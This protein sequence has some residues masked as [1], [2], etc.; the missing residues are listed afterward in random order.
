MNTKVHFFKNGSITMK[1]ML[2][3]I[4]YYCLPILLFSQGI[5][6]TKGELI[7]DDVYW[8]HIQALCKY[9]DGSIGI[10]KK[11]FKKKGSDNP[12]Y[13]IEKYDS[14]YKRISSNLIKTPDLEG[15]KSNLFS[16]H[17]VGDHFYIYWYSKVEKTKTASIYF[18][19][20][21]DDGTATEIKKV[22]EMKDEK[23]LSKRWG[24]YPSPNNGT[25]II[26]KIIKNEKNS[27]TNFIFESFDSE[28]NLKWKQEY[29]PFKDKETSIIGD[30]TIG[31]DGYMAMVVNDWS[32]KSTFE[33]GID[34]QLWICTE[35]G[36]SKTYPL[37][38]PKGYAIKS[39]LISFTESSIN[40]L[41]TYADIN[42]KKKL[43]NPAD[44]GAVGTFA[45]SIDKNDYKIVHQAFTPF[46]KE[47]FDY[48]L[49]KEKDREDGLIGLYITDLVAHEPSKSYLVLDKINSNE[50]V[51]GNKYHNSI[52][53]DGGIVVTYQNGQPQKHLILPKGMHSDDEYAGLGLLVQKTGEDIHFL[54]NDAPKNRNLN[55]KSDL[56]DIGESPMSTTNS[57][58]KK[59]AD[60]MCI[61]LSADGNPKKK[62]LLGYKE[63]DVFLNHLISFPLDNDSFIFITGMDGK[64]QLNKLT[65]SK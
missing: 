48:Y 39:T 37:N 22:T 16:L 27:V 14:N 51:S 52:F 36:I 40:L 62:F 35:K 20:L 9:N 31:K 60:V 47:V 53:S 54:Y 43:L 29:S 13:Y 41:G 19:V 7:S 56:E 21:A 64:Y 44:F 12:D 3:L 65:Y 2:V 5:T 30:L 6:L 32:K 34:Q 4:T 28:L 50:Y 23:D 61:T 55:L 57:L 1:K 26:K 18:S 45:I 49:V 8:A 46:P 25:W 58:V 15:G 42:Q 17:A 63:N 10:I 24:T 59:K 33:V 38:A 11:S